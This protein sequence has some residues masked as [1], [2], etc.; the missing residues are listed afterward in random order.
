ML[1]CETPLS[2]ASPNPNNGRCYLLRCLCFLSLFLSRLFVTMLSCSSSGVI[3]VCFLLMISFFPPT[4]S[5]LTAPPPSLAPTT[6][7][8]IVMLPLYHVPNKHVHIIKYQH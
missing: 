4:W 1:T 7:P 8:T 5:A 6:D 3:C 2:R